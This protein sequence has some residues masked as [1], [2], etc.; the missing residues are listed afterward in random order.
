MYYP[1]WQTLTIHESSP[2]MRGASERFRSQAAN[3]VATQYDPTLAPGVFDKAREFRNEN[4]EHQTFQPESFDLVITQDVFEHVFR[5][6]LAIA[7]IARTLRP[8]GAHI[9]TVPLTRRDEPSRRRASL[10]DD[11]VIHHLDPQYHGNPISK[12]GSLV[13]VDWGFDILEYF[14]RH[15]GLATSMVLIDDIERG[16]RARYNEVLI[17]RKSLPAA[18]L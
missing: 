6:D 16:I 3:Y 4:L 17:C 14:A 10:V 9:C 15:S 8:G 12:D 5:P 1:D 18:L 13:T 7:E 11:E 2:A